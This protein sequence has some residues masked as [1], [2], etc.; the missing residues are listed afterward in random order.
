LKRWG[1]LGGSFDPLH[2]GHLW[3]AILSREQIGLD[4]VLLIPAAIPPH[5]GN[6]TVAPYAFRLEM[7]RLAVASHAGLVASDIEADRHP[8]YTVDTLRRLR[9]RIAPEDEVWLLM[10]GDSLED[11]ATWREPDEILRLAHLGIYG[12]PCHPVPLP[13]GAR[14]RWITGPECGISS[15][16]I[17]ERLGAGLPINRFVPAEIAQLIEASGH[18]RKGG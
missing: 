17:R 4:S 16:M 11:L 14:A 3:I 13:A 8:S 9:E 5:K 15:T 1:V 6:G 12:R 7:I 18:Y 2:L 10:G